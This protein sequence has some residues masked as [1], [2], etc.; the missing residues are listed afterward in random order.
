MPPP[1]GGK[2]NAYRRDMGINEKYVEL[3]R[4]CLYSLMTLHVPYNCIFLC[5]QAMVQRDED[6]IFR[7]LSI[8]AFFNRASVFRSAL[9]RTLPPHLCHSRVHAHSSLVPFSQCA[10]VLRATSTR[11]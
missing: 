9:H 6:L 3:S 11:S 7:P 4:M 5:A 8:F 1:G 10:C 2:G